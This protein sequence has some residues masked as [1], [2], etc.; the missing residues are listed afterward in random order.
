MQLHTLTE[1]LALALALAGVGLALPTGNHALPARALGKRGWFSTAVI[2]AIM[3]KSTSCDNRG[4]ECTTGAVAAQYLH[5]AV[6]KY[7]VTTDIEKAGIAALIAYESGELQ[8][9]KNLDQ[10]A[11]P[12]RGTANMQSGALN[13]QYAADLGMGSYTTGNVLDLTSD[14][15]FNFY[16]AAWYYTTTCAALHQTGPGGDA[17]AWFESFMGPNCDGLADGWKT[18]QPERWTYWESAKTAFGV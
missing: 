4:D 13:V 16:S 9:K 15:T 18:S 12:G 17:D 2:E 7:G 14:D 8:Y 6:L 11:Q 1:A 5:R 10:A 3:P